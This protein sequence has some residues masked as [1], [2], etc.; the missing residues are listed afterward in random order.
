MM[1]PRD[2]ID[3]LLGLA[4]DREDLAPAALDLAASV[5]R[6]EG[7]ETVA[8]IFEA[9]GGIAAGEHMETCRHV[10][11]RA[12]AALLE[13]GGEKREVEDGDETA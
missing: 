7:R 3:A 9:E 2:H 5:L 6:G 4:E 8:D 13:T 1:L 12:L 11:S 10:Q